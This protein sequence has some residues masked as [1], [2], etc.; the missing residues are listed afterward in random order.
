MI[1]FFRKIRR[2]LAD[3]NKPLKYMRYAVG[4]IVLVVVGILIALQINNWNEDRIKHDLVKSQLLNLAASLKSDSTMFMR[5]KDVNE[6]RSSSFEYLLKNAGQSFEVLPSIPKS[7]S[8]F[9]W[10]GTYPDSIDINFIR[11]SFS[12]FTRGFNNII[13]DRTAM[14]EVNNLGLFSEI[15]DS[16]LRNKIHDYYMFIGFH[17]SDQNIQTRIERDKEFHDYIRDNYNMTSQEIPFNIDPF[18]FI[19]NDEGLIF[20][21]KEIRVQA[22]WHSLKAVDA[23]NMTHEII[24]MIEHKLVQ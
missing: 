6:F 24:E 8:T 7:D 2:Q 17:F 15:Q 16:Q 10:Q 13:I 4:E 11:K 18:E 20:R 23:I 14:N 19:K 3:D 22:N 5:T 21:L 9:I 12:W 1:K